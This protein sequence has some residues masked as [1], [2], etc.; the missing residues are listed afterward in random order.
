[1]RRP[2][3]EGWAFLYIVDGLGH[4]LQDRTGPAS[5]RGRGRIRLGAWTPSS[6]RLPET[7]GLLEPRRRI[8]GQLRHLGPRYF[9][10]RIVADRQR[11]PARSP[12]KRMSAT[13]KPICNLPAA[14][15]CRQGQGSIAGARRRRP[16]AC[17]TGIRGARCRDRQ[18]HSGAILVIPGA[19]RGPAV[20]PG[21]DKNKTA[22]GRTG[23]RPPCG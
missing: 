3:A 16:K 6:R 7:A 13:V 8:V 2:L 5:G 12:G 1:M 14:P 4:R 15:P 10:P 19:R 11:D 23:R 18:D 22:L 17:A 20:I 9:P 21:K